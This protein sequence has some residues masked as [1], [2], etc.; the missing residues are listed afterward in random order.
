MIESPSPR[1]LGASSLL[2]V[3][4]ASCGGRVAPTAPIPTGLDVDPSPVTSVLLVGDGGL[5]EPADPI[6]AQ[7]AADARA[8]ADR[9]PTVVAFLGDNVY[10]DGVRADEPEYTRD[11]TI[12]AVQ[13]G[14]VS[15]SGALALF[16]PGNHDWDAASEGGLAALDRQAD[17]MQ[18]ADDPDSPITWLPAS[19]G[20][21]G[22]AVLEVGELRLIALDTQWFLHQHERR[23]EDHDEAE[24]F[25]ELTSAIDGAGA[26]EV[27]ILAHHP[28]RT[29]GP[30]GGYFPPDRHLF[31]LRDLWS[32]A[33]VPL[34]VLGTAY[35]VSRIRG[36]SDQDLRGDGNER[37]REGIMGAI[38]AAERA[39]R[40]YAAGH[41]HSLQV[42][43]GSGGEPAY[44]L[45]SGSASKVTPVDSA[46][47]TRFATSQ[48]GYMKVEVGPERIQVS[49]IVSG[50]SA[51]GEP[52]GWCLRIERDSGVETPC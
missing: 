44:H 43:A 7:L 38:R 18:G 34:P 4:A 47:S 8:S 46:E 45:I 25:R 21:P 32:W 12:L 30:H 2:L 16:I 35:V 40:F 23:C 19:P 42:L 24:I 39:P 27:I 6:R 29:H 52:Q 49:V 15:G 37:M 51:P 48:K 22:P 11:T 31:P 5:M 14:V 36:I 10:P 9:G 20:C 13:A 41:E 28:L 33:F 50:R 3:L 17:W 1:S 26:R